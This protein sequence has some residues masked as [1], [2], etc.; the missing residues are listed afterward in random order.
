VILA[1]RYE[2][3]AALGS[4]GMADVYRARDR[5]LDREVA[6]KILRDAATDGPDRARF[7]AEARILAGLSHSGLVT[8][9]DA[10][11]GSDE[12]ETSPG[13]APRSQ[14]FVVMELVEGPTLAGVLAEGPL[15][16]DRAVRV[17]VP[18]A[19]ALAYVHAHGVVHRD[20]KPG[21]VLLAS[22]GRVKLADFGIAR[23]LGDSARHTRTGTAVGTAAYLAPEQVTGRAVSG[24]TDVYAL[25]LMLL[26]AVTGRREYPGPPAEAALAR[27]HRSPSVPEALP[28]RWRALLTAMT[29][30]EPADRPPAALV[31][32]QLPGLPSGPATMVVASTP[33][34]MPLRATG[35]DVTVVR[36]RTQPLSRA[37]TGGWWS[38]GPRRAAAVGAVIVLV[39][40]IAI[41]AAVAQSGGGERRSRIPDNT[42]AN[43]RQPLQH[44]H[45]A[46]EGS[47]G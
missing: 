47:T 4:G 46:V 8:V 32:E 1:G 9:L 14:P 22:D 19:T 39:A 25:G 36:D 15:P 3:G 34:T 38:L 37:R 2:L 42:P 31:A 13:R 17:A 44:L 21:N 26:E 28:G 20:V 7:V 5:V 23:L 11:F 33:V 30:M 43:L 16:L 29:A 18:V 27:L 45:S 6:V 41:V 35:P 12:P 10:G 24:A 40:A